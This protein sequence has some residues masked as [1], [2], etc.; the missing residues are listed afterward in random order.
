MSPSDIFVLGA[1][2]LHTLAAIAWVGGGIFYLF[3]LSPI[4]KGNY[5]FT[6]MSKKIALEF[7]NVVDIAIWVLV[8]TGTMLFLDRLTLD[9]AGTTYGVILGAKIAISVWMFY[10]VWFR[11][12]GRFFLKRLKDKDSTRPS[13]RRLQTVFSG[14]N[15]I[16]ILGM[17]VV[18]LSNI[19]GYLYEK[20]ISNA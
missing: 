4:F 13:L 10:L 8:V 7:K 20:G 1:R 6:D 16:L 3:A 2:W 11:W 15:L 9:Y 18:L 14:A 19:L 17:F 5:Q 12:R